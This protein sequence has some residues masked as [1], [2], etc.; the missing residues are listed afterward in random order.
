[1]ATTK[2]KK[3]RIYLRGGRPQ[4][5]GKG[6]MTRQEKLLREQKVKEQSLALSEQREMELAKALLQ[7]QEMRKKDPHIR[8]LGEEYGIRKLPRLERHIE[9]A[10]LI[11]GAAHNL[12]NVTNYVH[13]GLESTRNLI[14]DVGYIHQFHRG[15]TTGN[16]VH[17]KK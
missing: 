12:A 9:R 15:K 8:Y 7:R 14:H 16:R 4:R 1:M 2:T 3:G 6:V 13:R 17:K 10:N 5:T 11:A